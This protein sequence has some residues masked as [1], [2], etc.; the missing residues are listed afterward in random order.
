MPALALLIGG[1]PAQTLRRDA[2]FTAM[3]TLAAGLGFGLASLNWAALIASSSRIEYFLP[4]AKPLGEI[5]LLLTVSAAFVLVKCARDSTRAM[6]FL[7]VGW[8]L[9]GCSWCARRR[10]RRRYIRDG[11]GAG[12][13]EEA[14]TA[15]FYSLRTYDQSLTFYLRRTVTLVAYRGELDYG[16]RHAPGAGMADVEEFVRAWPLA[17][18]SLS[19]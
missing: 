14:R 13:P 18:P 6:V 9:L 19:Q 11:F 5:A 3:L 16:L 8:C 15:P 12:L 1:L 17:R 7:G 4:L 10:T 2:R